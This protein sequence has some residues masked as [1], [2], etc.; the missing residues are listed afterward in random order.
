MAMA[1]S[2]YDETG[3][4]TMAP[5][6][7][8]CAA[9]ASG[10]EPPVMQSDAETVP[11]TASEPKPDGVD[12]ACG[13]PQ[14]RQGT[15]TSEGD[16][17]GGPAE[18]A[19]EG[20][21]GSVGAFFSEGASA[22]R[23]VN[24][25]KKAHASARDELKR[26]DEHMS[27][28]QDELNYRRDITNR[29][30]EIVADERTRKETALTTA[31]DDEA[32]ATAIDGTVAGL[33]DNLKAMRDADAA[34]EKRLKNALD[35]ATAREAAARES[36]NRLQRRLDDAKR[37]LENARKERESG[38][39]AAEKNIEVT[40]GRLQALRDEYAELQRNP[41]ENSANYSVRT[42]ELAE[43]ISDVTEELRQAEDEL[44][45][46]TAELD[47]AI[48]SAQRAV[49]EAEKP[50]EEARE[51]FNDIS[52]AA[53]KARDTLD[54]AKKDATA[55][56][57]KLH[58]QISDQE[59][60]ARELRED[61][62]TQRDEADAAQAAIDQAIDIHEH[63]EVIESLARSLAADQAEREQLAGEIEQL[64]A[65]EK[66]VRKRTRSSRYKFIGVIAAIIVV[67]VVIVVVAVALS[68]QE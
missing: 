12:G 55:R 52:A 9:G 35:S 15:E 42:S 26:L 56:Q 4:E 32:Q 65:T 16:S 43:Q 54:E 53:D 49:H 27:K 24:A 50:I 18:E 5:Q 68:M 62:E 67:V 11:E 39:A 20:K 2:A 48:D 22:L 46:V 36:G 34:T 23:E 44:P 10:A 57:K 47:A 33:K 51:E 1:E 7:D 61:A 21:G 38:V 59:K 60:H 66:D 25:A 13:A 37:N 40:N 31:E 45:R 63:P 29:F 17:E 3:T 58:S 19:E 14:G 30:D 28:Q 6:E 41:S 64:A 8:G